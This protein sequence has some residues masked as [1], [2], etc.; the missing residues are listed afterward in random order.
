MSEH[1]EK[2]SIN[3]GLIDDYS[4]STF[5]VTIIFTDCVKVKQFLNIV[6]HERH[7]LVKTG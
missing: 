6:L 1:D 4:T 3:S 7:N 5:Q 2:C